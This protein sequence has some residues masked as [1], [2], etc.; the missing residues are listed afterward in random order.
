MEKEGAMSIV[1]RSGAA[2]LVAVCLAVVTGVAFLPFAGGGY[3]S[4]SAAAGAWDGTYD[5]GWYGDGSASS[6]AIGTASELAALAMIVNNKPEGS[7]AGAVGGAVVRAAIDAY[8]ADPGGRSADA[9][10]DADIPADDFWGKTVELVADIDLGGVAGSVGGFG[11]NGSWADPVWSGRQWT[12]IGSFSYSGPYSMGN[13]GVGEGSANGLRGRPFKGVFDGG[14]HEISDIYVKSGNDTELNAPG[15]SSHGLFGELGIGGVVKNVIIE[16]GYIEGNNFVGG[17]VGRNWGNIQNC[18]NRAAIKCLDGSVGGIVGISRNNDVNGMPNTVVKNCANFGPVYG[19]QNMC[20]PGGIVGD[21]YG[22][23]ENCYNA[24][25]LGR[26]GKSG[27]SDHI[28]V[29]GITGPLYY[30]SDLVNCYYRDETAIFSF[31]ANNTGRINGD[32][33]TSDNNYF[34]KMTVGEMKAAGFAGQLC[35]NGRAFVDDDPSVPLN[36]GY[37]VLRGVVG[38]SSSFK[39]IIEK[40]N[41]AEYIIGQKFDLSGFRYSALFNDGTEDDITVIKDVEFPAGLTVD[42]LLTS[43]DDGKSIT[44]SAIYQEDGNYHEALFPYTLSVVSNDLDGIAIVAPPTEGNDG[45]AKAREP[46]KV[47]ALGESFNMLDLRIEASYMD[48]T[49]KILPAGT[50]YT[51]SPAIFDEPG[52]DLVVTVSYTENGVTKSAEVAGVIVLDTAR[53]DRD[54]GGVYQIRSANDMVWMSAQVNQVGVPGINAKLVNDIDLSDAHGFLPIGFSRRLFDEEN[55]TLVE[56]RPYRLAAHPYAGSFYGNGKT[57]KVNLGRTHWQEIGLF[58]YIDGGH[59]ENLTVTGAIT[60]ESQDVGGIAGY[61]V[62]GSVENVVNKAD[63]TGNNGNCGGVVGNLGVYSTLTNASNEGDIVS[64]N[65]RVGGVVGVASKQASVTNASNTGMVTGDFNVGG[66]IGEDSGTSIGLTNRGDVKSIYDNY[67]STWQIM[68]YVGA[69]GVVGMKSGKLYDSWNAGSVEAPLRN[70]GGVAGSFSGE[71]RNCYNTGAVRSTSS[72][73]RSF[74]GG[75]IGSVDPLAALLG[76]SLTGTAIGSV[77][78]GQVTMPPTS[79]AVGGGSIGSAVG[80]AGVS[81]N[82]YLKGVIEVDN[83]GNIAGGF[84]TAQG[85]GALKVTAERLFA[86]SGLVGLIDRL[87]EDGE[88]PGDW[89]PL[90]PDE[91]EDS[92]LDSDLDPDLDLNLD[93]DG[94]SKGQDQQRAPA[95]VPAEMS[96]ATVKVAA[97]SAVWTG[98]QVKPSV[99]VTLGGKV[100]SMGADYTVSYGAN[101]DIG[102]GSVTV[103]AGSAAYAGAKTVSFRI[104]PKAV[105]IKK[106]APGKRLLKATWG[107]AA[108]AQKITGCQLQYRV[109]GAAK[110]SAVKSVGAKSVA[111]TFKKLKKGKRYE[112][113]VRAYKSIKSGASKGTYYGAWSNTKTSKKLG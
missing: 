12:P 46:V 75:I 3:A 107:R 64:G 82:F 81:D 84:E 70:V 43:A 80:A 35:G 69:G 7:P 85:A 60:S 42:S 106:L 20:Y 97:A 102:I 105:S 27:N 49:V 30:S 45:T 38:E 96:N 44:V 56:G 25:M 41:R 17:V 31:A 62:R 77:N 13:A 88:V 4:A 9:N 93:S 14:F 57:V 98:R 109:K 103:T 87:I 86:G 1:R 11:A 36:G 79:S 40:S 50:A 68:Y 71:L 52:E 61:V 113:R 110:W 6:Y 89:P 67:Q 10:L 5:Y 16:S 19:E 101:K 47:Y 22:I 8:E 73:N 90:D 23:V 76:V 55:P 34:G 63:I 18:V 83:E 51:V 37:P 39:E 48:G 66:V 29:G 65:V 74:V 32:R 78:I 99:L 111:Y 58:G 33:V 21:S 112:V 95:V 26:M 100:L 72:L 15:V 59:V 94:Q 92:D 28:G 91:D 108:A 24:G 104:D 53:P 54:S 2:R